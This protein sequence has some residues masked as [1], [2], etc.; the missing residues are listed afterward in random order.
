MVPMIGRK[1]LDWLGLL[2]ILR[3]WPLVEDV[4]VF[5]HNRLEIH[6]CFAFLNLP[7][8]ARGF[9]CM[10]ISFCVEILS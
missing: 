7:A 4:I 3:P 2:Q 8:P 10:E 9:P 1:Y 5:I 6:V